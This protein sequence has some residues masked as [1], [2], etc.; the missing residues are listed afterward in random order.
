MPQDGRETLK[1]EFIAEVD[2]YVD[3]IADRLR[4]LR[5]NPDDRDC[6]RQIY[7]LFHTI[8][9][10]A[11]QLD[12]IELSASARIAEDLLE[13]VLFAGRSL[14]I[15]ELIFLEDVD[16]RI[17]AYC[18]NGSARL[19]AGA[20][21][22]QVVLATY[23]ELFGRQDDERTSEEDYEHLCRGGGIVSST[24]G[25]TVEALIEQIFDGVRR[26]KERLSTGAL[27]RQT[28]IAELNRLRRL[29]FAVEARAEA[30]GEDVPAPFTA[31]LVS[32]IDWLS[33]DIVLIA[34]Q[35][36][37]L[38]ADYL[39][40]FVL[41]LKN[42]GRIEPAKTARV[43][44]SMAQVRKIAEM[45]EPSRRAD[46]IT[47]LLDETDLL[48]DE[49]DLLSGDAFSFPDPA[50]EQRLSMDRENEDLADSGGGYD[51]DEMDLREIFVAESEAHL[52]VIGNALI[53]L[54]RIVTSSQEVQGEVAECLAE[55]RRAVHTLKGAAA[56][57]G[58]EELSGLAHRCED[59]LDSFFIP[60]RKMAPQDVKVL[61]DAAELLESLALHP[62]QLSGDETAVLSVRIGE[63]L[64]AA[65]TDASRGSIEADALLS[66]SEQGDGLLTAAPLLLEADAP[67]G[68]EKRPEP[69]PGAET[70][71]RHGVPDHH[72]VADSAHI[73]VR[74]DNLDE[75]VGLENEL[76]VLRSSM[77]QRLTELSR[78]IGELDF[79]GDK[80]KT[81]SHELESGFEVESLLGFGS[82]VQAVAAGGSK[83]GG[84]ADFTEF[85]P[86]ELDRYTRLH[87]IIRS[88]NELTV[89]VGS[90]YHG[91]S[92]LVHE[93]R[94][95]VANQQLVMRV[96]QDKLMR[97][98]MTPL[99]AVSRALFRTVRT[100]AA[101]LGKQVHLV[102]EGEDVFLDRFIWNKVTDPIMHMLRNAVDHGIEHEAERQAVGKPVQGTIRLTAVQRGSHVV[103]EIADDGRG[104]D[105]E[106][107]RRK[108]VARGLTEPE[109]ELSAAEL[110][111]HLFLPGFSTRDTVSR[112]SGRGVG[113]DVVRKNLAELRGTVRVQSSTGLGTTFV[114]RIPVSLSINRAA[115]VLVGTEKY[116]VPLQD[117]LEI[118]RLP[119][120]ALVAGDSLQAEVG[121]ERVPF[122]DL[123][124]LF[125][126]RE[127]LPET[128]TGEKEIPV[129]LVEAE[130]GRVALAIDG[131]VEQQ[132][133][134]VKDLG[135]HLQHIEG[136]GGVT[137]MGDGSLIPIL[138]IS[139][140][141]APEKRAAAES[142][143][144]ETEPDE[145]PF[146]VMVVDDSVSVRQS[147][148][149]LIKQNGWVPVLATDGVDAV[150]KIEKAAPDTVI[151]DIE[152]P[153]MNGFE[154]LGIV[155]SQERY[156]RI[157]VIML[158]SRYS[159][160]HQKK[161]EELG[162]DQYVIK[163]YKEEQFVALLQRLAGEVK[164]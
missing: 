52:Q 9:G 130:P 62:E 138:N 56:M 7:R 91:L 30:D 128:F 100:S 85:D 53:S 60:G 83:R 1:K 84:A 122:K 96:M 55:M 114:L 112:L 135:S 92:G 68:Q 39:G 137:I 66:Q 121:E 76:I 98:R 95:H 17:G 117:I 22:L 51:E 20:D 59:L 40:F 141:A 144:A 136:I 108:L 105:T 71:D 80:L 42:S 111:D 41:L 5:N 73:R 140:L 32:F 127:G 75:L 149:R 106:V 67:A 82:G 70:H 154:F 146:T 4:S 158:T 2:G 54:D 123:A 23:R 88:L 50:E 126:L 163:P 6:L 16:E 37:D 33:S 89:D 125:G 118:R 44:E 86:I 133:I 8:K 90:I 124:S 79:A 58:L 3:L 64:S 161:A 43:I 143:A 159:E 24:P 101:E 116:A 10:S 145:T 45:M 99:S 49:S 97:V 119:A 150:E 162:A 110:L 15:D 103:L 63:I 13:T 120:T 131:I 153:R 93:M 142:M 61:D 38:L 72:P 113:L 102:V 156:R 147:V 74:L 115:I 151:L 81:I 19:T 77:D 29:V 107:I 164:S 34:E 160:K 46:D 57:T 12:L 31:A 129:L 14:A 94:G 35:G 18:K 134:I 152:M 65:G 132:E 78:A 48:A 36:A 25:Y 21:L 28:V 11:A 87:L 27:D 155:R 104:I 148:A 47:E 157:P 26:I 139:E 109:A 69:H